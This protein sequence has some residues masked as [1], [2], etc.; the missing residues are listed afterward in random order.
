[1]S[2]SLH[3]ALAS[4]AFH[5]WIVLSL[6]VTGWI[7]WRGWRALQFTRPT[8]FPVWRLACFFAGLA[9][10]WIAIASP[11]DSLGGMLLFAHMAQHLILDVGS[12]ATDIAGCSRCA[13]LART[14]P[15]VCSRHSRS[16]LR[17]SQAAPGRT[18]LNASNRLL[19][20]DECGVHWLASCAR[21]RTRAAIFHLARSRTRMFLLHLHPF[22]VAR[23]SSLA[24]RR[25]RFPLDHA[26][27]SCL[28]GSGEHGA[29]RLL[30]LRWPSSLSIVWSSAPIIR[31]VSIARP[32]RRGRSNVGYR[33]DHISCTRR[34]DHS[35]VALAA[36]AST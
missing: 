36:F 26:A 9:T 21:L 18:I 15:L 35:A 12:T 17:H 27:V 14:A 7:Y 34:R 2:A 1:M 13:A 28:G 5:P 19:A 22:L 29:L 4:W 8:Q 25:A 10:L 30:L 11:L 3:A 33:L 6:L 23:D 31:P 16:L 24:H 20:G 32:D